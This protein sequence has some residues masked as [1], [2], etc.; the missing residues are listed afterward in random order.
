[1]VT[2][3]TFEDL[4][5][6]LGGMG[7]FQILLI[8]SVIS[9][10]F[11][12][13]WSMLQMSYAGLIPSFRCIVEDSV[14]V[15]RNTNQSLDVCEVNGTVC[16]SYAF[17]GPAQTVITEWNL[18]C[19]MK[20]VK[21]TITSVQMGGVLLGALLAGQM[22][23]TFGRKKSLY[24]FNLYHIIINVGAAFSVSWIMFVVMR[25]FI[26]IGI[27]AIVVI[28]FTYP[29]E[30]LPIKWRP[31]LSIVPSWSL[32]VALF[33]AA[34]YILDNWSQLHLA[35]GI[36]SIPS[37]IGWFFVPESIRWLTLQGN[38]KDAEKVFEKIARSN[39]KEVPLDTMKV[40]QSII[41]TENHSREFARS[42]TYFDLFRNLR[43]IK[44]NLVLWLFWSTLS[45]SFYGISFGVSSLSGN[46]YLNIFLL[47]VMELPV[48]M[49]TFALNN[50]LGRK[51]TTFGFMTLSVLPSAGCLLAYL[52]APEPIRDTAVNGLSL[53]AK[54]MVASAWS[55]AQIWTSE[56][57]PTVVRSLGYGF[58]NMGARVGG[59]AAPFV[60]NFDD[61]P[62][63]AYGVMTVLLGVCTVLTLTLDETKGKVLSDSFGAD[64]D[65]KTTEP[66]HDK[67][68]DKNG[69]VMG[70][71]DKATEQNLKSDTCTRF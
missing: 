18:V 5:D 70:V 16:S 30:F 33:S 17:S 48:R 20:W 34:A 55:N 3:R 61:M 37:L 57:Y 15:T 35:C 64:T 52:L 25:F 29:L 54:M 39:G 62:L 10:Q 19:D 49:T 51:V 12:T 9:C 38:V 7:R 11:F 24:G 36:L 60:V 56:L 2:M 22:S 42:Y 32:G 1:M 46:L 43:M 50:R 63:V 66:Q 45:L 31:I 8:I 69:E 26:G 65:I 67:G 14:N 4:I 47:A 68:V 21:P 41:E 13:G 71:F 28:A 44:L 59:I 40:L 6:D 23:D 58:A 27:G 53:I